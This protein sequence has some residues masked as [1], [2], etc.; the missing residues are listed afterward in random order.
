ML[1]PYQKTCFLTSAMYA[2]QFPPDQGIE[3]ALAGYSNAGKSSILNQIT[4]RKLL[5][6]TSKTPGCTRYI[7]FFLVTAEHRLVD[8]PGYGFAKVPQ[9]IKQFWSTG[10]ITYIKQ[11]YSLKGLI[12][13][14]DSRRS[15]KPLDQLL[16]THCVTQQLPV[17]VVFNKI[18][19]IS[20]TAKL[21]CYA[22]LKASVPVNQLISHQYC[23][24][25]TRV[26]LAE[27]Y[28]VLNTWYN[29]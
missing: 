20:T 21:S 24:T 12:L 14:V 1:M 23:S 22:H 11:R 3:I 9:A 7:N 15:L 26:G 18:D 29:L 8:L 25:R 19:K 27:L 2:A 10:I 5:A 17:H 16:L 13:V 28:T 6:R 4:Q